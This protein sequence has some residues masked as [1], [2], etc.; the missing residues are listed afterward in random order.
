MVGLDPKHVG[1]SMRMPALPVGNVPICF[2]HLSADQKTR[3]QI[4]V[5]TMSER[6]QKIQ[7]AKRL[8]VVVTGA[9]LNPSPNKIETN[10]VEA[11]F[12]HAREIG[13]NRFR[14]PLRRPLHGRLRRHPVRAHRDKTM[15][16]AGE[17]I[18]IKMHCRQFRSAGIAGC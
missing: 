4:D 13:F 1:V 15:A 7:L 16:V 10:G 2:S 6:N 8:G 11:E 12:V 14:I 9:R 5:I 3:V 18:A 17:V